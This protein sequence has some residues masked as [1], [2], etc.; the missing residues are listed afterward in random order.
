MKELV[1]VVAKALV[2]KGAFFCPILLN[3][4][5]TIFLPLSAALR[6]YVLSFIYEKDVYRKHFGYG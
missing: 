4:I 5:F 1:E 6:P 2:D 3:L